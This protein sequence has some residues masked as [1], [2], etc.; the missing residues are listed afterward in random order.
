MRLFSY[1]I[2][3]QMKQHTEIANW[4]NHIV[5]QMLSYSCRD[6]VYDRRTYPSNIHYHDYYELVVFEEGD[7]QYACEGCVYH[8]KYGDI[9]LIPP[10]KFHMS[11]IEC[12]NT[13]YKRHV[14]YLYPSAF[15]AIGHSE[16]TSFLTKTEKGE[17]LA[18][19]LFEDRQKLM[20]LLQS[21]EKVFDDSDSP[22][23]EALGLS[24]IIQIFYYC[25]V[26]IIIL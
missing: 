24:Y 15:D 21:L 11:A 13:R 18:L 8:P 17:L 3:H 25:D 7:I 23:E 5:G 9:I 6:T 10:G 20:E 19:P 2:E 14:F 12:E 26:V 16:L 1:Y 22:L 4:K